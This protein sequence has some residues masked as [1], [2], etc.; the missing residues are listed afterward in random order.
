[1]PTRQVKGAHSAGV[2][3]LRAAGLESWLNAALRLSKVLG[4]ALSAVL[5]RLRPRLP[6]VAWLMRW[7][8]PHPA[9]WGVGTRHHWPS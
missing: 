7:R 2:L 3:Q 4:R 6:C 5:L 8:W 1:M 9:S